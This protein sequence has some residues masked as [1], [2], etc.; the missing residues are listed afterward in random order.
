MEQQIQ[1]E[2]EKAGAD[3]PIQPLPGLTNAR[4]LMAKERYAGFA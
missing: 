3:K 4:A 1:S 2:N